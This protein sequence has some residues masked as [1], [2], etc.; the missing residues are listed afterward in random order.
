MLMKNFTQYLTEA[1]KRNIEYV[2]VLTQLDRVLRG[3]KSN[4]DTAVS[5]FIKPNGPT[6]Y[7]FVTNKVKDA[8]KI[9]YTDQHPEKRIDQWRKIYGHSPED[10]TCIGYWSSEEFNKAGE[11]VFFWDHA[12]HSKVSKRGYA[13]VKQEEFD[14]FLSDKG[15][16]LGIKVHYSREFYNKYKRLLDGT[17]DPEDTEELSDKLLED[18][19]LEMKQNIKDGTEDFKV[20]KFDAEGKTTREKGDKIWSSPAVYSNTDLQNEAIEN[21]INA[22]NKGKKKLL[23]AAVMRFG[24][25]HACYEIVNESNLKRILVTSAKA[26]VRKA[27]RDD[28]NHINYIDSFVFIEINDKYS[29]DITYKKGKSLVTENKKIYEGG[30]DIIEN[31]ERQDKTIIFFAT[32]HD[33][34]G[35]IDE[36]KAKHIGVFDTP[37]DMLIVDETHYGSHANKFGDV[38]G[39]GEDYS[40]IQEEIEE[41]DENEKLLKRLNI[42]KD[43]TLQVSG[44]PYYI[45]AS[46]EMLDDDAEIISKVSYTDMLT[47]RDKW[48]DEHPGAER[49]ESPYFGVPTLHKI[50]LQLTSECKKLLI[51]NGYSDSISG[52]FELNGSKKFRFEEAITN[53]MKSI[54][55]DG[56]SATLAFMKNKK[57]EGNKVCKH[58]ILRLPTIDSCVELKNILT[59]LLKG[60][61]RE[62]INVVGKKPDVNS[63]SELN[64][65]LSELDNKNKQ[66]IVLTVNKYLTGVSMPLIDSMI[67]LRTAG[68]PQDYDQAIFRLCT[69]NVKKVN[70]EGG[71]KYVNMKENVYLI[72]FNISNMF[73]MMANSARMKAAAEGNA[74]PERIRE[75]IEEELKVLPIFTEQ[76]DSI[77]TK[78]HKLNPKD[79]MKVYAGYNENKSIED[80]ANDEINLFNALFFNNDF[81]NVIKSFDVERDKSKS[82]VTDLETGTDELIINKAMKDLPKYIE[83]KKKSLSPSEQKDFAEAREKFKKIIKSLMYCNLCL[84]NAYTDI[85]ILI[86]DASKDDDLKRLL[87]SFKL[88][89]SDIKKV[90]EMMPLKYKQLFNTVLLKIALLSDSI[91]EG[92]DGYKKWMKGIAGLGK[93]DKSE[94]I[95]P[96]PIVKKMVSK[97]DDSVYKNAES[98]LLINEKQAEF[99]VHLCDKFGKESMVKKCKIVPSSEATVY[100]MKKLLKTMKL[101]DYINN[102]ILDLEDIDGNGKYDINDF[103]KIENNELLD[104]NNGKKFDVVLMNPPYGSVGGDTLH[105]KFVDKC[106]DI[107]D[108]QVTVMPFTLVTKVDHK[109]SKKYKEKFSPYLSEVEEVDSK[110]FKDTAMPNVGIYVFGDETQNIDIKYVN[111]QNETLTSLLDK[112]E[113]TNYEKEFIQYL[114]KHNSQQIIGDCGRLNSWKNIV[115]NAVDYQLALSE[116]VEKSIKKTKQHFEI[117]NVILLVN[118]SNGGMNGTA[119]S[120]KNGQIF[121]NYIDLKNFFIENP[122][123]IGYNGLTFKSKKAAQNCKIALQ[124]P[125]LRFTLYK[126]QDDQN[127]VTRVY[128]YIPA[129]NWEDSRV[130][131]DEGLLEVCGCP[132]DKC[133]EYADYC[134]KVIEEVDKKKK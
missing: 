120:S 18:I 118:R 95:T 3:E 30:K 133:K 96:E 84:D 121:D 17:I 69:R 103:L 88:S 76:N 132:K 22:I 92:E 24:K 73:N 100:L 64:N 128:K 109:P 59:Q 62:V 2:E 75:L 82:G 39:L 86:K 49:S 113:F 81:R 106:L 42:Q 112:S 33:L 79:L 125:L 72:D 114:G 55:G 25:T 37:F 14:S 57:V 87:R 5:E 7:A 130:K 126:L 102:V 97:L 68:S 98:I 101:N 123:G 16:E 111:S 38:T 80:I 110:Y 93:I 29:W 23:M 116:L 104:M 26:D 53:L 36:M 48:E 60:G 89:V 31:F 20:F 94:V 127:M 74:S 90:Y 134:R 11:R 85:D 41:H 71:P 10:V 67:Y 83:S 58:T 27:W 44:T 117:E 43:I 32:L 15:K 91:S 105:L 63:I 13:N 65:R 12:V 19:I 51:E 52:L 21:A 28:I 61:S 107:A 99:F 6:I 131:T 47:A 78:M 108:Y 54:F 1:K 35:S 4:I 45:L 129:I 34:A 124:N 77:T 46:N 50:G 66:S 8:I 56:N 122:L 119:I 115:N 9:G 70:G 40:D